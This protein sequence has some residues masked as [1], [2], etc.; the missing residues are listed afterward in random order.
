MAFDPAKANLGIKA[1]ARYYQI[2]QALRRQGSLHH[3][4]TIRAVVM[5]YDPA[6][7]NLAIHTGVRCY[8]IQQALCRY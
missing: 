2:Q 8:Q 4:T 6:K 5:A 3:S 7:A 1:G